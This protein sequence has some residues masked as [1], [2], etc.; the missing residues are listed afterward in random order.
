M[1]GHPG[2]YRLT[3]E[4]HP[5]S[6]NWLGG[7]KSY[8]GGTAT[9]ESRRRRIFARNRV[10]DADSSG[11]SCLGF[12][13]SPQKTTRG[14]YICRLFYQKFLLPRK[15]ELPCSLAHIIFLLQY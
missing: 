1:R 6:K 3:I 5:N 2:D 15:R 4:Q 13:P 8:T 7:S 11:I 9:T 12:S 14:L 10:W